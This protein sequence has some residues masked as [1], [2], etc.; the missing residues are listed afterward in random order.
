MRSVLAIA[1]LA[2]AVSG[3]PAHAQSGGDEIAPRAGSWGAEVVLGTYPGATL[4]RFSSPTSAWLVGATFNVFR[5]T[6]DE[7]ATVF[8]GTTTRTTR[9]AANVDAR[10]GRRWWKGDDTRTKLRPFSGLGLLGGYGHQPSQR[11]WSAG[12]YGEV[13]ATYFFTPHL[14]L[15][16]SGELAMS[17]AQ[18]RFD[19]GDIVPRRVDE[20]WNVRGNLV[21]AGASVYF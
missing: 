21:R 10:V 5:Q 19:Y 20:L 13:G 3:L 12:A 4:L 14:S 2:A 18:H 15:G 8:P 16:A 9:V 6:T 17:Y 1:L 11:S 7:S